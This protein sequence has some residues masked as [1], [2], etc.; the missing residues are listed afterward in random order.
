MK[1]IIFTILLSALVFVPAYA[2]KTEVLIT[3]LE[4][5]T[6]SDDNLLEGDFIDFRVVGT[7]KKLRGLIV[8]YEENG[9]CGK[10]AVLVMDQFRALNSDDKYS[11]TIS[12]NGNQ[13]N[14]IMEF[15]ADFML[16]VRGGEVT[17]VPDKDTFSLWRE[18]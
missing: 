7:E 13:H 4:K 14:G 16:Y 8:K 11:G 12:I 17:I 3:P 1:K 10:E 5:V 2:A 6:T 18:E 15:F 9:F